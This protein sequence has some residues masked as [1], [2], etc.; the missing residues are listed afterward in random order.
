MK[1]LIFDMDGVLVDVSKSYRLAIQKTA[2]FFLKKKIDPAEIQQLKN[3]GGYNN[4]WD[5][6][7]ALVKNKGAKV[8]KGE[9][10]EKFQEYYLGEN[11][12]GLIKNEKWLL[13]ID[14]LARLKS[15]YKLAI[16]TGR[17]KSEAEYALKRFK[18]KKFFDVVI[19]M[20]DIPKNKQKPNPYGLRL[21][22]KK[23]RVK[24]AV[25]LGDAVD[26][27]IM[28]AKARIKVIGI[29]PE[30]MDSNTKELLLDKGAV[31]VLDD[32]NQ[33]EG[34]LDEKIKA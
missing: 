2:G 12:R 20:D 6:T 33:L 5:L 24:D 27:V 30:Y 15:K 9:L 10:I 26:D 29:V 3:A 34:V 16:L 31:A 25:Y 32:I 14:V 22:T 8:E 11:F 4:D 17:P 21:V 19:T 28:A 18:V 23:L 1:A 7:E 13:N